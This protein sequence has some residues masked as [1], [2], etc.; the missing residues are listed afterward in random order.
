MRDQLVV[1]MSPASNI[2]SSSAITFRS[3][4]HAPNLVQNPAPN[5]PNLD[6]E[7]EV[8]S[9]LKRFSFQELKLATR[10]FKSEYFLGEGGFGLELK[11]WVTREGLFPARSGMKL[12]IKILNISGVQGHKEWLVWTLSIYMLNLAHLLIFLC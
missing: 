9:N 7:I 12:P 2:S 8:N 4:N 3:N 5:D 10:N 6:L 1:P 11:G